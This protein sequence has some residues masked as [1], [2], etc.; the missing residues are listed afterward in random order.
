MITFT[1]LA[2][3]ITHRNPDLGNVEQHNIRTSFGLAM[4]GTTYSN[5]NTPVDKTLLLTFMNLTKAEVDT[6]KA[7]FITS[8]TQV[9]D[10]TDQDGA[11]WLGRIINNPYEATTN[12]RKDGAC[13]E[14]STVNIE[15]RGSIIVVSCRRLLED[16]TDRLLEDGTV[17]L[18]ENA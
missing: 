2:T 14:V 4:D 9:V 18:L 7:F 15:F 5:K 6:F 8:A 11:L 10:Y 17:R 12:S 16:G 3:T 1:F 13:I